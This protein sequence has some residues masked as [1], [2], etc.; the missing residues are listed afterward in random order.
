MDGMDRIDSFVF[1]EYA[2][3]KMSQNYFLRGLCGLCGSKYKTQ[4]TPSISIL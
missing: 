2:F 3:S 1:D 4:S